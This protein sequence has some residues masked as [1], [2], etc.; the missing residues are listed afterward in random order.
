[1]GF[2]AQ[3]FGKREP[4]LAEVKL[5]DALLFAEREIAPKRKRLL[6]LTAKKLAEIKHLLRETSASLKRLGSAQL[7]G[8]SSRLDRI[9]RTSKRN[10]LLQ[11][12]SLIEKLQPVNTSDLN[13]IKSYCSESILALQQAGQFGKNV[14][15]TGIS[16]KDEMKEVGGHLKQLSSEFVSLKKLLDDYSSVF[17][18]TVLEKKLLELE[19]VEK[20]ASLSEKEIAALKKGLHETV[21]QKSQLEASLR[22]LRGGEEFKAI[23]S[24]SERKAE[25]LREKQKAKTE[26]LDMFAKVEKPLHRLDKAVKARK[27]FLPGKQADLL[28]Y[29]LLNPFRA[30]KLDPKAEIVKQVLLEARK[31]IGSGAIELKER[32]KEKKM[33]VLQEMLSF[34]FFGKS[35]WRF[36]RLDSEILAVEK[37]LHEMPA[38]KRESELF[39]SI[40]RL[41][42]SEQQAKQQLNSQEEQIARSLES[43][44]GLSLEAQRILC[45]VTGKQVAI[46][47]Q[48]AG[49]A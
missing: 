25:L 32:E 26:L 27:I 16:F 48:S 28:H 36:N 6:E 2:F 18:K 19:S 13:A 5:E 30:L 34:D 42:A 46:K 38:I 39:S 1:M 49:L 3:I 40:K 8:N 43:A 41:Q 9:V 11:L 7:S 47:G 23:A 15:Y 14:A 33:A 45:R 20:S 24:L 37:R 31:A 29:L 12:S 17:L 44:K 35:F 10:A 4:E 21:L 22:K